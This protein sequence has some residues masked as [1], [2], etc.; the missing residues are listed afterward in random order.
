M[1]DT[2]C[3]R[4]PSGIEYLGNTDTTIDGEKCSIWANKTGVNL[5]YGSLES[6]SNFC[7]TASRPG[8]QLQDFMDKPWCYNNNGDPSPCNV[9]YCGELN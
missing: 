8:L 4:R 2:N 9:T 6:N 5:P 1:P 7:R 3:K